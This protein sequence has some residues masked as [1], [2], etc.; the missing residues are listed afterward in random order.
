[1]EI[2]PANSHFCFNVHAC[3]FVEFLM[4]VFNTGELKCNLWACGVYGQGAVETEVARW[5]TGDS[6]IPEF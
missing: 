5:E 3:V 6:K 2:S 1:M 4:Q